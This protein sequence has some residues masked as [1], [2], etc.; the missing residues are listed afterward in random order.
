[1]GVWVRGWRS[2]LLASSGERQA[3]SS[4]TPR[5]PARLTSLSEG[6]KPAARGGCGGP[7][8]TP[9]RTARGKAGRPRASFPL[10]GEGTPR[11]QDRRPRRAPF[12]PARRARSPAWDR[13]ERGRCPAPRRAPPPPRPGPSPRSPLRPPPGTFN[14]VAVDGG[15][16]LLARAL[17][18]V[19]PVDDPHL[20][21]ESG[22]AALA[23]AQEQDLHKPLHRRPLTGGKLLPGTL[24]AGDQVPDI[25]LWALLPLSTLLGYVPAACCH[26][27]RASF[28]GRWLEHYSDGRR[29][30]VRF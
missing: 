26:R 20:L 17:V 16:E 27:S 4:S 6:S 11:K 14:H 1:M 29:E 22:L 13:S 2:G 3:R 7:A 12:P 15:A 5:S 9:I 25:A 21:Q 8:V 19:L 10:G 18:E 30:S 23:R 24:E 28:R